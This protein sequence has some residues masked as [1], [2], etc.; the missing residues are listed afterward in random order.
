VISYEIAVRL[1]VGGVGVKRYL[2]TPGLG[3]NRSGVLK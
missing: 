2:N 3:C 1:S